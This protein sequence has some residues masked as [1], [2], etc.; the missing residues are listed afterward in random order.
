VTSIDERVEQLE[1]ALAGLS[2][3]V[4]S[5]IQPAH[6]AAGRY[7]S[8]GGDNEHGPKVDDDE[9]IKLKDVQRGA[10]ADDDV[11]KA[12]GLPTK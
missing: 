9:R 3:L 4:F 6:K 5:T 2:D 11:R 7:H 8:G 1:Q 12:V 10:D